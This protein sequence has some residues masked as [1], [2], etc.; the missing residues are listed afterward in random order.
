MAGSEIKKSEKSTFQSLEKRSWLIV[1]G[2]FLIT[3]L[4]FIL[5]AG[6]GSDDSQVF[7]P[8][9]FSFKRITLAPILVLL[10]YLTG[11]LGILIRPR[12]R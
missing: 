12:S 5:M 4:G 8:E 9:I 3:I 11:I 2:G 6:G 1:L 7:N 10:G